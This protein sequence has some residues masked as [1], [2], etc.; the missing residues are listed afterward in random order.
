MYKYLFVILLYLIVTRAYAQEDS[1]T[2][3]IFSPYQVNLERCLRIDNDSDEAGLNLEISNKNSNKN[4]EVDLLVNIFASNKIIEERLPLNLC[5]A[6][7]RSGSMKENSRLEKL[8]IA[9]KQILPLLTEKDFISIVIYDDNAQIL[10]PAQRYNKNNDSTIRY[11]IDQ[12]S[13]GGGTNMMA[14]MQRGYAEVQKN[15]SS[16]HKN[17][18][19]LMS[20]G[21]STTG[22][23]TPEKILKHTIDYSQKG[24]ETSTIGLGNNINFELLHNIAVEGKG[25]SHFI[26]DCDNIYNDIEYVLKSELASMNANMENIKLEIAY[27]KQLD[28]VNIY[29][30]AK[31]IEG[32]GKI[33]VY[34]SGLVNQSQF[35]LVKFKA[36][37]ETKN[38]IDIN[39]S[40]MEGRD[41]KKITRQVEYIDKSNYS[42]YQMAVT[43]Q[44]IDAVNCIKRQLLRNLRN[45]FATCLTNKDIL[46]Y[47]F[48]QFLVQ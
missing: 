26:G 15:Y 29:G 18:L 35:I 8:K 37:R 17:R 1:I 40:Y 47:E 20:D 45:N 41:S 14:G 31:A 23:R 24:I 42:S 4:L 34:T 28:F 27:P 9:L 36:K 21:V 13:L 11:I 32:S 12:I 2:C 19:I 10:L 44:T 33:T 3:G 38:F 39:L 16:F 43:N 5:F 7:D 22:E 30:A 46:N 25:V 48:L 6:L